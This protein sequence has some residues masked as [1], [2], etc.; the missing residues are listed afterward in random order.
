MTNR[1]YLLV[2]VFFLL[3]LALF[4]VLTDTLFIINMLNYGFMK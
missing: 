4:L 2:S 1:T 3:P